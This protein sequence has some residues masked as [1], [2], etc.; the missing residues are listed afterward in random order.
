[1]TTEFYSE[2]VVNTNGNMYIFVMYLCV[3]S[4]SVVPRN[5]N[6]YLVLHKSPAEAVWFILWADDNITFCV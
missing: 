3:S 2:P 1:M 5:N 6:S 4:D